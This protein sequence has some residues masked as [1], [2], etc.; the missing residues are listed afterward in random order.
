V[1]VVISPD[2]Q[3]YSAT[4]SVPWV[5]GGATR[6]ASVLAGLEALDGQG[7]A[8][9]LIHD[10]ARP[11]VSQAVID[12]VLEALDAAAE[13]G[14]GAAPALPLADAL[15]SGQSGRVAKVHR[16]EGLFR[17][18]T[19]Q[20]FPFAAILAAHRAHAHRQPRQVADDVEVARAAGMGIT[21]VPGDEDNL[22]ITTEDDF[23]RLERILAG[24]PRAKAQAGGAPV[25]LGNGFDVHAFASTP[26]P[27]GAITLCGV[28]VA[29][30]RGLCGHSDADVGIHAVADAIYGALAAGDIGRHF[31]PSDAQWQG[32]DSAIFLRHATHF[33]ACR[34]YVIG[35]VD[36]TLICQWPKIAPYAGAMAARM[37][38][39]METQPNCVS[40]KATTSERLGF[41]GRGEGIAALATVVLVRA[42]SR[43]YGTYGGGR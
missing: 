40:I 1:L 30:E 29:H 3:A 23:P 9:V 28:Q 36:C 22:K 12:R 42:S 38:V 24:A 33:A 6:A 4:L 43:L 39:L 21:I 25:R 10:G 15:W 37:A 2:D 20:G 19:P 31:P 5:E 34:G 27:G 26:A 17:A 32:A 41:T 35:N 7:V 18:Q 14:F 11:M 16:R 13:S 8:R